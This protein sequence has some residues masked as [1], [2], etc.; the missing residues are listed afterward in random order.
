VLAIGWAKP[1]PSLAWGHEGHRIVAAVAEAKLEPAVRQRVGELLSLEPGSTLESISDWADGAK[2][3]ATA[4]WHYVNLP[5][6]S[7]CSYLAA[8][9][10]PDGQCVVEAILAQAEK[11]GSAAPAP[12]RLRALKYLVHLVG[13][14]HQPLH[15]GFADDRGGNLYQ[16]QAFGRGTNLHALWDSGLIE[17]WPRGPGALRGQAISAASSARGD[18]DP[19]GW[20]EESCRLVSQGFYPERHKVGTDYAAQFA[21]V[22]RD[23]LSTGGRR[24]AGLLN[25]ALAPR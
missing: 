1:L 10:C 16:L 24:L 2:T 19:A 8:R 17:E 6:D 20:A 15:A 22:L 4:R 14:V 13:D 5:R 25:R 7:G 23:R 11:L 12:V 21:P 3:P 18:L 9:D